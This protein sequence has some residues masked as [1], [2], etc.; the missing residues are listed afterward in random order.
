MRDI[1]VILLDSCSGHLIYIRK[2]QFQWNLGW[3]IFRPHY[4]EIWT[5]KWLWW[6]SV[7]GIA[8]ILVPF[9]KFHQTIKVISG[10]DWNSNI[11][12]I[13][14][15]LMYI[16]EKSQMYPIYFVIVRYITMYVFVNV[17]SEWHTIDDILIGM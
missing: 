13:R 10:T 7:Q 1:D 14:L 15:T 11:D 6:V 5:S 12:Q 8:K 17:S 2:F 4:C 9:F 3:S 16:T